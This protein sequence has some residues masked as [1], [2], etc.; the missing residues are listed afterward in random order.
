MTE[1]IP[2]FEPPS[3]AARKSPKRRTS[4]PSG[5][6][7]TRRA[8]G[9]AIGEHLQRMQRMVLDFIQSRGRL[10][11][12]DEEIRRGLPTMSADTCR[13]RRVELRDLGLIRD[14]GHR[15][16]TS[17][18]RFA[19]CWVAT[20]R[21]ASPG[22][23]ARP[24]EHRVDAPGPIDPAGAPIPDRPDPAAPEAA[25][26]WRCPRCGCTTCQDVP[27]HDG[28]STRRDCARC[29]R[30][31]GFPVWQGQPRDLE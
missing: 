23:R 6:A 9:E 15:R 4:A 29:G 14:S 22:A 27:I 3:R 10:G 1:A 11:A 30:A 16:R 19:I 13:G 28:R 5:T 20:D 21:P 8:A 7:D 2:L 31:V 26:S 24:D 18:G 12:T 25:A 17:R